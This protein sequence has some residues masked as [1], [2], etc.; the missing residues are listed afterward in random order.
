MKTITEKEIEVI[1]LNY[2]E[3][4]GYGI[5]SGPDLSPEGLFQERLY[6][7]VIL[8][9]R[10]KDAIDRLN[11]QLPYESKEEALKKV[12]RLGANRL[13][14]DNELFHTFLTDGI[15][16]EYR[17]TDGLRGDSVRIIDYN[18]PEDN[19]FL[20][21][22][23]F[24][25]I[26]K[27]VNKRTDIVLFING[28]PLVVIEL[29]NP[30]DVGATVRT[31]FNQLQT[32]KEVIPSLFTYNALLI[33][34]D[35]WEAKSGTITSD[36]SRFLPWKTRDGR[37]TEES[38]VPQAEVM[39]RGMLQKATLL[40]LIRHF[41]VFESNNGKIS[42][43]IAAYHQFYAVNRAVQS[44]RDA[45]GPDG[46]RRAGV[47]WHTQGSGKSLSMVFYTGKLIL[48]LDNPTIV[49]L[50]D[51]NDLDDQLFGTF[52][53]CRQL[54]RQTPVQAEDRKQLRSLLSV[55]SGGIVFTTIQKFMP[56]L[57]KDEMADPEV[58]E[59]NPDAYF[60]KNRPLSLR[61]NIVVIADE[62]HRSQYD[63]LDG[64]AKHLRDALPC[65]SFIGF[66]GTPIE[67]TDRNTQAVFGDYIDVYDI[68]QAVQDG[69]TV[70]I[71]YEGRLAKVNFEED[72][73]VIHR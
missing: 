46:D 71:Y 13:V 56:I 69:A 2:L 40:D 4:L 14:H 33:A 41:I 62:A 58:E 10:L 61:K 31:A 6:S 68:H 20:A 37:T 59:P 34:S 8:S 24:T 39:F 63:F 48:A 1:C 70:S 35:G 65:A 42:K 16:I 54:L 66:T 72:E 29:K 43:K 7:E 32:Y 22:N 15:P 64:F 28:L 49:V 17:T 18:N 25:V 55:A 60:I 5:M 36:W 27:N 19:E 38:A 30:T 67:S 21:V 26:E 53:G 23:Q 57:D 73:K 11:P 50:T 9:R 51:R 44:T 3:S 45:V 52:Y 47:I 12:L